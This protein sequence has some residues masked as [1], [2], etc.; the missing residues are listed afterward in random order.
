MTYNVFGWTVN[1]A[2]FNSV[3]VVSVTAADFVACLLCH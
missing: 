3:L 2:Q 1:L